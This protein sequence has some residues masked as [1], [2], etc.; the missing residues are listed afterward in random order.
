M[1]TRT[2][3]LFGT[4]LVV[5]D[6]IIISLDTADTLRDLGFEDVIVARTSAE[7]LAALADGLAFRAVVLDLDLDG[8][9]ATPV[10][11]AARAAGLPVIV[12]SGH[13]DPGLDPAFQGAPRLR[14]PYA[15]EALA[16]A[17][18]QALGIPG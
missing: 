10:A 14:K 3:Q 1:A 8:E 11:R 4:V 18:F 5:E 13:A 2:E 16:Q 9:S 15:R 6:S 17:L 7:A 12:A